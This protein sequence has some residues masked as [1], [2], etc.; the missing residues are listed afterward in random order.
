M[1][2]TSRS[3][4]YVMIALA[5][6]C[7]GLTLWLW[8]RFAGRGVRA[9]LG[10]LA[11]LAVTQCAIVAALALAVNTTFQFYGSWDELLGDD[12]AV[13]AAL[14]PVQGG[15]AGPAGASGG[16]VRPAPPQGLDT[17]HGLSSGPPTRRARSSRCGSWAAAARWPTRR[18]CICRRSTS[19][20]STPGSASR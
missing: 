11:A 10:R 5:V 20:A 15:A 13:P 2:L 19:S 14:S 12:E 9:W 8:P 6:G 17:V 7:A 18:M 16:L 3:L 1:G 4:E